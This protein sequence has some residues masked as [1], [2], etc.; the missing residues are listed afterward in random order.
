M[1]R[2]TLSIVRLIARTHILPALVLLTMVCTIMSSQVSRRHS[3]AN[4][5]LYDD[6]MDRWGTPIVQPAPSVR[7]VE[8]GSVFHD[9]QPLVLSRQHVTV[10]ATMNYRKRGLVYFSGFDFHFQ[11]DYGFTN[12]ERYP[13]DV[14]F[15][16]PLSVER[17]RV[18]LS[19]LTFTVDD[20]P[21]PISLQSSSDRLLWTGRIEPGQ[22]V[23]VQIA[24]RGR[25]LDAFRYA[26][27][28]ALP[29]RGL[30]L[31]LNVT[32]GDNYDY[33]PGVV[34]ATTTETGSGRTSLR[35]RYDALEAGVP[36]GAIL[37]SEHGYDQ[38]ITT[39]VR[40]AWAP[41]LLFFVGL[42]GLSIQ[43]RRPL[44]VYE[45]TLIVSV[46]LFTYVLLPYLAAFL[47]FY[48]AYLLAL[49]FTSILIVAYLRQVMGPRAARPALMLLGASLLTPTFA[50]LMVG[51]TGLIYTLE[52]FAGLAILMFATTRPSF[53][54]FLD[55]LRELGSPLFTGVP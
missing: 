6:V 44:R 1:A 19:D 40:R 45:T 55:G 5:E 50:V 2:L 17:D 15:V 34:P 51:Y 12:D 52:I 9:L 23:S 28:P 47:H 24:Y 18:L 53:Q 13:I 46:Y 32:G 22:Q 20:Q 27:D 33:A 31:T 42:I 4:T 37:P 3:F 7:F 38:L 11:G 14:A 25:G 30:D 35:W 39:L 49:T 48:L 8:H 21:E 29:V 10:D 36:T 54:R 16:F 41:F 26:L 43:H